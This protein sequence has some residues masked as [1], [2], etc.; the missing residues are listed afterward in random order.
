MRDKKENVKRP[1]FSYRIR[2][3]TPLVLGDDAQQDPCG[4]PH[5]GCDHRHSPDVRG[6]S[7]APA[8]ALVAEA[9]HFYLCDGLVHCRERRCEGR[10]DQMARSRSGGIGFRSSS[11]RKKRGAKKDCIGADSQPI[12]CNKGLDI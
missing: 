9:R 7:G 11:V 1:D 12:P 4:G 5:G 6:S 3:G 10:D 2:A 8:A